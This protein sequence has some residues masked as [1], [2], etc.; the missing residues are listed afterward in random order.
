MVLGSVLRHW[1]MTESGYGYCPRGHGNS[2]DSH[3]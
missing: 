3:W 2:L 1:H